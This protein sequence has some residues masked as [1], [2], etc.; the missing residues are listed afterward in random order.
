MEMHNVITELVGG[1][2]M[3]RSYEIRDF[4]CV[5]AN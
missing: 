4:L 5:Y 1:Y 2:H 3:T